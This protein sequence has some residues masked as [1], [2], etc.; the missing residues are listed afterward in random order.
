MGSHCNTEGAVGGK[1]FLTCPND[2]MLQRNIG[3]AATF[4]SEKTRRAVRS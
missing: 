2:K 3:T 4:V 1:D